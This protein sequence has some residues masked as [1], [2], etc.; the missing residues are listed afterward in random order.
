VFNR[1]EPGYHDLLE[2]DLESE[3]P[4]FDNDPYKLKWLRNCYSPEIKIRLMN[5]RDKPVTTLVSTGI[6]ALERRFKGNEVVF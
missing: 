5:T 3:L 2:Y 4:R 1:D 6:K